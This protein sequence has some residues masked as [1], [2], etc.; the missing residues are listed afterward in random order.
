MDTNSIITAIDAEI[1]KLQ[2]ARALL[3]RGGKLDSV[4]LK[5]KSK[6][7]GARRMSPEGRAR[8]AEAQKRR[9]AAAKKKRAA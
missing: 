9:W 2:Q 1:S 5:T 3:A 4:V 6:H 7:G 8:I